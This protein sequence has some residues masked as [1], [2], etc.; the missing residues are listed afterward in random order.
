MVGDSGAAVEA[1]AKELLDTWFFGLPPD[2]L[3][4][5]IVKELVSLEGWALNRVQEQRHALTLYAGPRA[6][7]ELDDEGQRVPSPQFMVKIPKNP[8]PVDL[9]SAEDWGDELWD[10]APGTTLPTDIWLVRTLVVSPQGFL[11]SA[12]DPPSRMW[13]AAELATRVIDHRTEVDCW[14]ADLAAGF[15]SMAQQDLAHS[16]G[17]APSPR[18]GMHRTD[19]D[20]LGP[21]L[22]EALDSLGGEGTMAEISRQIW[23]KHEADLRS[24]GRLFYTW[25]YDLR[26][27]AQAYK[28]IR[29]DRVGDSSTWRLSGPP[30][31]SP[32][33]GP[34]PDTLF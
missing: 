2:E 16:K 32:P 13:D 31:G 5:Q 27:V 4:R 15:F 20:V 21:W 12:E 14:L 11:G 23:L 6:G 30:S 8:G 28:H 34:E 7:K 26:W 19:R 9:A 3:L 17:F 10:D 1:R 33:E 22:V 18:P 29:V 25:Q 24:K